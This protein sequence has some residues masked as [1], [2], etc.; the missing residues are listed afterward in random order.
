V[1]QNELLSKTY[2]VQ[3][4]QAESMKS[5]RWVGYQRCMLGRICETCLYIRKLNC[6]R[7]LIQSIN[8]KNWSSVYHF[9]V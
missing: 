4:I 3:T 8:Y 7:R 2:Y 5:V 1:K 9:S 6:T